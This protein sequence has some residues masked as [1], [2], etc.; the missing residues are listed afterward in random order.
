[1]STHAGSLGHRRWGIP[2]TK[3]QSSAFSA[4]AELGFDHSTFLR[5][6]VAASL[7]SRGLLT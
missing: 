2:R 7:G 3:H 1:M 6:V 4:F 5:T